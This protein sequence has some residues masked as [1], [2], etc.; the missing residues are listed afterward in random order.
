MLTGGYLQRTGLGGGGSA[1]ASRG[2]ATATCQGLARGHPEPSRTAVAGFL[3]AASVR[4]S[5]GPC[6][7][8]P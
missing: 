4:G 2:P 7:K 5:Q 1:I 6:A 8:V 3:I